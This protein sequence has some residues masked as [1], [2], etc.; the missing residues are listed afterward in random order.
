VEDIMRGPLIVTGAALVV[1]ALGAASPPPLRASTLLDTLQ[2]KRPNAALA[3]KLRLYGRFVGSWDVDID[4]H[5]AEGAA[6]HARAEWHFSWV[7]DGRAVQD[8]FIFPSR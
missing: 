8:V 2:S 4:Y 6:K 1:A 3:P 5:P 7:L